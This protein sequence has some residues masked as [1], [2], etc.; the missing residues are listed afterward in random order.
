VLGTRQ[1]RDGSSTWFV[2]LDSQLGATL[3]FAAGRLSA[4]LRG[5]AVLSYTVDAQGRP[6]E[7]VLATVAQGAVDATLQAADGGRRFS[8]G[9]AE[10][11]LTEIEAALDL[12]DAR[13]RDAAVAL[14]EAL[15]SP[16]AAGELHSRL[17]DVRERILGAGVVD[18]RT[19]ALT[20]E[21]FSL[22]ATAAVGGRLGGMFER[23]SEGMHLLS[24]ET[25]L[26]GLPFL[27][28]DDCR[29]T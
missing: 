15:R 13:N 23:T 25:R 16:R 14:V 4:S 24:A 17:S 19:Y 18:R 21:A 7:L 1:R 20:S 27:P 22:G 2:Q 11:S 28:R 8:A 10:G 9:T 26:P 3:D 6:S 5:A 29:A 12:H